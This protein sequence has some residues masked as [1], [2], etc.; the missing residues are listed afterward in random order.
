MSKNFQESI[1]IIL[2]WYITF[3]YKYKLYRIFKELSMPLKYWKLSLLKSISRF[4]MK[5]EWIAFR[6]KLH[7]CLKWRKF[8]S[9]EKQNKFR[10]VENREKRTKVTKSDDFIPQRCGQ[11]SDGLWHKKGLVWRTFGP[12]QTCLQNYWKSGDR[13]H[14][15]CGQ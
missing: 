4:Q 10:K 3:I 8:E 15:K 1:L 11:R 6:S 9:S 13:I 14:T 7:L 5:N 12:N 2:K